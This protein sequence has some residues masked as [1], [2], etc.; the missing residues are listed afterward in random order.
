MTLTRCSCICIAFLTTWITMCCCHVK[1]QLLDS[2]S[3]AAA[4]EYNNLRD[5][6]ANPENVFKL[7]LKRKR[8]QRIPEE[9]F[10]LKN[11]NELNLTNNRITDIPPE[12][13]KLTYLQ[14]LYM[15]KNK[16]VAVPPEIAD[17]ENLKV[18]S[19]NRNDIDSLPSEIGKMFSLRQLD[20]WG[21]AIV[22][23]PS[24]IALLRHLLEV[25]DLRV[26]YMNRTQQDEI[27]YL[28]PSTHILFSK[29]CNCN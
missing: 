7:T 24:E 18:L 29:P 17:L 15:G 12:I 9:V 13:A 1:A 14:F 2:A 21:T 22:E 19:L 23:L 27:K 8:L 4:T 25:L 11:L 10:L 6:L 20:L 28:L 16:L 3:L 26:I 5:A